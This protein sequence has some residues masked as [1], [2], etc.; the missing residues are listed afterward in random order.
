MFL[1]RARHCPGLASGHHV[2]GAVLIVT[3][4]L[5]VTI[6]LWLQ[7]LKL[8]PRDVI[9]LALN[10]TVCTWGCGDGA[11]GSLAPNRVRGCLPFWL[12]TAS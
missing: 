7:M 8:R 11:S 6:T 5:T 2:A 1:S 10:D 3:C 9:G 12:S 4:Q